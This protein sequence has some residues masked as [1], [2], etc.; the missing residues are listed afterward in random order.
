MT[1]EEIGRVAV[2]A[3]ALQQV[4]V[5]SLPEC[6][7]VKAW[8]RGAARDDD[9]SAAHLGSAFRAATDG[10]SVLGIQG[11]V[12]GVT[13]E[14]EDALVNVVPLTAD[15]AAAFVFDRSAPLGLVRIQVRQLSDHLRGLLP[16]S[17]PVPTSPEPAATMIAHAPSMTPRPV[18]LPSQP[19][20]RMPP[21]RA[22]V[23]PPA[24]APV[25]PPAPVVPP[26]PAA[27]ASA[28]VE[29]PAAVPPETRSRGV[30]LMEFFERYAPDPHASQ[31][32]LSLRTGISLDELDRP[33]MLSEEQVETVA[34]AV[35]D[36]LGQE[37]V[38]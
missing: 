26:A 5:V 25:A 19:P 17:L 12:G 11:A 21:A 31:L 35:R 10:I 27:K 14:T 30:R 29:L 9:A 32:R 4:V 8:S 36:I 28:S 16:A 37:H 33:D 1:T 6:L 15:A 20:P 3:P 2:G 34:A 13:I 38:G 23:E 7:P 22:P 24:P 18:P